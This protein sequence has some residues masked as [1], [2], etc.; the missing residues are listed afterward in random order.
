VDFA[1]LPEKRRRLTSNEVDGVFTRLVHD[2]RPRIVG[3]VGT[4]TGDVHAADDI[5]QETLIK[6][7]NLL[8]TREVG[9]TLPGWIHRV[10]ANAAR[11]Y[12]R[13]RAA[14]PAVCPTAGFARVPAPSGLCASRR[15]FCARATAELNCLRPLDRRICE[16]RIH[17][18]LTFPEIGRLTG[19]TVAKAE[20]TYQRTIRRLRELWHANT[21]P[22][23]A[24]NL[25]ARK[26]E[27]EGRDEIR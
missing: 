9:R 27:E 10:A 25:D 26:E 4:L 6:L 19:A 24:A 22:P 21:P 7:H 12:I 18:G 15:E 3:L 1:Y 16:L 23:D 2:L 5:A 11:D 13:G 20:K 14:A 17:E 8:Q